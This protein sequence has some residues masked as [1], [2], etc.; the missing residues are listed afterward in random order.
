MKKI[1]GSVNISVIR[2]NTFLLTLINI[3]AVFT[4][5]FL[6]P[7]IGLFWIAFFTFVM[8]RE[9][10]LLQ[11]AKNKGQY[12]PTNNFIDVAQIKQFSIVSILAVFVTMLLGISLYGKYNLW[13]RER[14]YYINST[15]GLSVEEDFNGFDEFVLDDAIF[16]SVSIGWTLHVLCAM[17]FFRM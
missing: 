10:I 12:I 6:P 13:I 14:Y 4:T 17:K 9:I 16:D 2:Q 7:G 8:F 15:N 3:F 11:I 5:I 1:L